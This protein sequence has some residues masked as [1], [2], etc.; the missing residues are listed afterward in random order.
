MP[1]LECVVESKDILGEG[2]IWHPGEQKLYWCDNLKSNIQRYD[3]A[4]GEHEIWDMPEEVGC[5][6]FRENG[7]GIAAAMKSGFAFIHDL[8]GPEIEY[9]VDP[10]PGM[11]GNRMNDGKC[12]RAGRFWCGSMDA[13]LAEPTA[14]LYRL[15]PDLTCH[16]M[17]D[18][19]IC[20]NGIAWSPDDKVMFFSDSKGEALYNYDFDIDSGAIANRRVFLDTNDKAFRIDGGTVDSEGHY[21]CAEVHDWHIGKYAADGNQLERIEMPVKQVT[22]CTFGGPDLDVLYATSATRFLGPGDAERQPLAGALFAITG[23]GAVG[24]PEPYFAG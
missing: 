12:D 5:I 22:M 17:D 14:S 7:E 15:D 24:I 3:P 21:W 11:D 2:V 4:T 13:G 1:K 8:D 16:K 6:V 10:E 9:I 23:T 19:I 20:S 18:G